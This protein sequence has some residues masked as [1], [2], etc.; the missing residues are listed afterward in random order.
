LFNNTP[1]L[2]LLNDETAIAGGWFRY[3]E[4]QKKHNDSA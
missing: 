1:G 3:I 2:Q 4:L